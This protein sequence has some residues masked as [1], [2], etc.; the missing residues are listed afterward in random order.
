MS[1]ASAARVK[2]PGAACAAGFAAVVY[3]AALTLLAGTIALPVARAAGDE[4]DRDHEE[5]SHDDRGQGHPGAGRRDHDRDREMREREERR[6]YEHQHYWQYQH[7]VYVPPPVY[8][9]PPQAS[10]GINFVLP[11]EIRV[12]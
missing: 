5:R 6:R 2:Q 9:Y 12:R 10:P 7:P 1:P 3:G 4:H 11:L 8:A